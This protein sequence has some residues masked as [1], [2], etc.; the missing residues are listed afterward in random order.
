MGV[1]ENGKPDFGEETA[2]EK[3]Q[4]GDW[5]M[6]RIYIHGLGQTPGSW[7]KT[8]AALGASEDSLRPD[9]AGLVRGSEA[10]YQN[11]YAAFSAVCGQAQGPLALCGLSLGAVLALHYAVEHPERVSSL[12]LIA[13][14]YQMPKKLLRLQNAVFRLMPESAFQGTGF[15]KAGF[16]RLCET[17]LELDFSQSLRKVTCPTLVVCGEKDKANRRAA[18]ELAEGLDRAELQILPGAGHEVNVDAPDKLAEAL[19]EFYRT[20]SDP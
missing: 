13:P 3:G 1:P 8:I 18:A 2:N 6:T 17:M 20:I 9:L 12:A 10:A 4:G 7:E 19:R 11:L 5:P 14:Q 15:G 16:L